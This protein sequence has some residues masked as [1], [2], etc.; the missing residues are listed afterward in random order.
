MLIE[1]IKFICG[2]YMIAEIYFLM[3]YRYI[4]YC[5]LKVHGSP[6]FILEDVKYG[7]YC[8][9]CYRCISLLNLCFYSQLAENSYSLFVFVSLIQDYGPHDTSLKG[10]M[11]CVTTGP[12]MVWFRETHCVHKQELPVLFQE[13]EMKQISICTNTERYPTTDH[14]ISVQDK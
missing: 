9:N 10:E 5:V 2:Q 8:L 14:W 6:M 7:F 12:Y 1:F 4:A 3:C 13:L 11:I